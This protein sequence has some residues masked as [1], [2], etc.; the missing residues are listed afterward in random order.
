MKV[1][2][3]VVAELSPHFVGGLLCHSPPVSK[4]PVDRL[5]PLAVLQ[6]SRGGQQHLKRDSKW[7]G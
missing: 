7:I 4:Q 5:P 1:L 2:P 6:E 3:S